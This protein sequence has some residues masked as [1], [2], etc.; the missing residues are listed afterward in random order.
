MTIGQYLVVEDEVLLM[1]TKGCTCSP[2]PAEPTFHKGLC[3]YVSL[4]R[5]PD[6]IL[7]VDQ[8]KRFGRE[9]AEIR[10]TLDQV[11]VYEGLVDASPLALLISELVRDHGEL[12]ARI[13]AVIGLLAQPPAGSYRAVE[14]LSAEVARL[15]QGGKRVPDTLEGLD[16]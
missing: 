10:G 15:L 2:D 9:L 1:K 13:D 16:D 6:L 5:I 4:G 12:E 7:A 8:A 14:T 3:G 11:P